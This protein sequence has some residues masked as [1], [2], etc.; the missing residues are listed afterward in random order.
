MKTT[1][2]QTKVNIM[3]HKELNMNKQE[4]DC[5]NHKISFLIDHWTFKFKME[6][7]ATNPWQFFIGYYL[8]NKDAY[9]HA[10][11]L[12]KKLSKRS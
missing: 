9:L 4:K 5:L 1:N 7:K 10:K 8:G 11:K 6:K 12:I 3:S 2:E